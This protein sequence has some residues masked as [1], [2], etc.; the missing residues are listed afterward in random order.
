MAGQAE[1]RQAESN[2]QIQT[3]E[4]RAKQESAGALA[5]AEV[6]RAKGVAQANKIIG[7]SLKNN[8]GYLRYL[9]VQSLQEGGNDVIYIP[10]EA[11]IPILE[12][13]RRPT[14]TTTILP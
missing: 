1:L 13:G 8:E 11:N 9:W 5:E 2:R 7:D 3:L 10:T 4:A 12:A 6:A 14:A